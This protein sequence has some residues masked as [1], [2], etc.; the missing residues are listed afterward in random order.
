MALAVSGILLVSMVREKSTFADVSPVGC[1]GSG[2]GISLFS[3]SMLAHIGD[4]LSFSV[5]VFN[6]TNGGSIVCDA[7]DIQAS[8]VTPDGI[9][10]PITLL[11]TSLSSGQIDSY[12]N[13]VTYTARAQDA[14][15][16][17]ILRVTA[18]DT[19]VIHQN[20]VDSQGGSNQGLNVHVLDDLHIAKLVVNTSGGTAVASNFSLHVKNASTGLDVAGSP[21][22]GTSTP[23]TIYSL[24]SG[25]YMVSE[26]ATSSYMS[27]VSGDCNASGT[28]SLAVGDSKTCTITNTDVPPIL[29]VVKLVVNT[30]GGTATSTDFTLH[31]KSGGV[32]ASGSPAAGTSTPGTLYTL[33]AGTFVVSEDATSSYTQSLSGDCNASGTVSL[34]VGNTKTCT[35]TN[36]DI[37]PVL[38]VVK[39]VVNTSGGTA[40]AS[41]FSLHVK[42]AS[43]GIDVSGSPAAGTPTPGT[44][45]MLKAGAFVVSEDATSSYTQILS[46]DCNASGTVTLAVGDSKTCTITNTDIP[47]PPAS[48]VTVPG[49][50]NNGSNGGG[51]N[52][53]GN[54]SVATGGTV[55]PVIGIVL[56]PD[57]LALPGGSGL[58]T[59]NYTV[60]NVGGQEPL[61]NITVTDNTCSPVTLLSGD[62]NNNGK[63]DPGETWKYSC[64]TTLSQTTTNTATA[65]G[66]S[67]D[68]SNQTATASV[69]A[70][71]VIGGGSSGGGV[72]TGGGNVNGL[73]AVGSASLTALGSAPGLPNTGP[74]PNAIVPLFPS[75]GFPPKDDGTPWNTA[76]PASV[77]LMIVSTSLAIATRKRKIKV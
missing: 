21:A 52:N 17:G 55:V 54:V 75:T 28:V 16:D 18:S 68:G 11:R 14:T 25:N 77:M 56:I 49:G 60:R 61:V 66:H 6:G 1:T 46:G 3:N 67:N 5:D 27:S 2:L 63:L 69:T 38:H 48:V 26:D 57:P 31:V 33:R 62:S 71:V 39:L 12:P 53:G 35:I 70:T 10:H 44:L 40:V 19:G 37:P 15:P 65:T 23:G 41:N 32:D 29:H 9:T 45:Y 50:G 36:T 30:S 24:V 34:S 51:G 22:A 43:S 4:V 74:A 20:I 72:G 64:T 13:V 8:I 42:N 47:P 73:T 76:A 58:I 59:Y 7:T